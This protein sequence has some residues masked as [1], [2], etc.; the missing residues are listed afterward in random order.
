MHLHSAL[1]ELDRFG[2]MEFRAVF[3][4]LAWL[5]TF[6]TNLEAVA[7]PFLKGSWGEALHALGILFCSGDIHFRAP[8]PY[9]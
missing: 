1:E 4:I 7:V 2:S 5:L 9:I 6:S 3:S 8:I